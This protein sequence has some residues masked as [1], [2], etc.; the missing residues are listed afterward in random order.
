MRLAELVAPLPA[1]PGAENLDISGLAADSRQ[2]KP[3]YLF[4]AITG[5]SQD[6]RA[7]APQ[8]VAAGAAAILA[9][10]GSA[11]MP[12]PV[13]E[14]QD[15]RA[16][17]SRIAARF[18]PRQPETVVAVTG[19]NGKSS[20][21]EFLRQIWVHAGY[22]AASMGT[23]GVR[24]EQGRAEIAHTTPDPI[25]VH[26]MLQGLADTGITHLAMEASSHG[27]KQHR[28]DS[29]RLA[30][31]GFTNLTQDHFDY[32]PN[33]EDYYAAKRRVFDA[34]LPQGAPAVIVADGEWGR[35]MASA[36]RGAGLDVRTI[37]FAGDWIRLIEAR[38]EPEG[39]TL[40]VQTAGRDIRLTLPLI[41][42]FQAMNAL[43]AAGLAAACGLDLD[44]AL[45]S[46]AHLR[47]VRGRLEL[48]GRTASG[49]QV[50]VDY[51]HTPDGIY[52]L[53]RTVRPH[54]QGQVWIVLGAGGD[55][56]PG[57]RAKMGQAA[58]RQA[59]RVIVTDDNPRSEDPAAIRAEVLKGVRGERG[60]KE[61][62][63]RRQA[64]FETV[65]QIGPGD[66]LVIAGKGHETGQI[67]GDERRP[68]DDLKVAREA[69]AETRS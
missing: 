37:G 24:T 54:A 7:F 35:R 6:G 61:I 53:L 49:A 50:F 66:I 43:L 47:G 69:I 10:T 33:F 46:I 5:L 19:T 4:A 26:R 3:G 64:I 13:V 15:V 41:G 65:S 11:G 25:G 12:G 17:L 44:A 16:A 48:A 14:A 22:K 36:A 68:F 23:L 32:H 56:D 60:A 34:L 62:A 58:A 31:A 30:A 27:L 40:R 18:Y 1:P 55:R 9:Q 2:V 67:Y 8:A 20:T 52:Q 42:E 21:V 28:M 51:A 38:P 63:D 39:Q 45:E 59:D 29:V 57:K